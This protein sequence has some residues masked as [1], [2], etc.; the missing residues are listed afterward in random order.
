MKNISIKKFYQYNSIDESFDSVSYQEQYPDTKD[1]YQPYCQRNNIDD[2]HRLYFHY[3]QYVNTNLSFKISNNKKIQ[4]INHIIEPYFNIQQKNFEWKDIEKTHVLTLTNDGYKQ[5]TLLMLDGL[6]K[7]TEDIII[8]CGDIDA[9]NYFKN[10][11]KCIVYDA[12]IKNELKY[13][14]QSWHIFMLLKQNIIFDYLMNTDQNLIYI[15]G[16]VIVYN[17][18][19]NEIESKLSTHDLVMQEDEDLCKSLLKYHAYSDN[20]YCLGFMGVKNNIKNLNLFSTYNVD[21]ANYSCDQVYINKLLIQK[22]HHYIYK[23]PPQ[24][25]VNGLYYFGFKKYSDKRII[26]HLNWDKYFVKESKLDLM[27]KIINKKSLNYKAPPKW[28]SAKFDYPFIISKNDEGLG[29]KLLS[30]A[31]IFFL[32]DKYKLNKGKIL[33]NWLETYNDEYF[34]DNFTT[35]LSG[36]YYQWKIYSSD[37][38]NTDIQNST[39]YNNITLQNILSNK[40]SQIFNF[41]I[42]EYLCNKHLNEDDLII[43]RQFNSKYENTYLD[44]DTFEKI[45]YSIK[46]TDFDIRETYKQKN[47]IMIVP[48]WINQVN[49]APYVKQI[50]LN[51]NIQAKCLELKNQYRNQTVIAV[52]IRWGDYILFHHN[53][54]NVEQLVTKIIDKIKKITNTKYIYLASDAWEAFDIFNNYNYIIINKDVC[55]ISLIKKYQQQNR[56]LHKIQMSKVDREKFNQLEIFDIYSLSLYNYLIKPKFSTFSAISEYWSDLDTQN[57]LYY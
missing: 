36:L 22:N 49:L 1:F 28:F 25:Y 42:P 54:K 41:N 32:I 33:L 14:D 4:D 57:I 21:I 19:I 52:H 37:I 45:K 34:F 51:S 38:I 46:N 56:G 55:D 50:K 40:S 15:D 30:I 16:D 24:K 44:Y 5:I 31:S 53:H 17:N 29:N 47:D 27:T 39:I 18:F 10:D 2:K 48:D 35:T 20:R 12:N 13:Y 11:Y 26:Q 7:F 8:C 23:L 9:Y 43:L 6:Q 3:M